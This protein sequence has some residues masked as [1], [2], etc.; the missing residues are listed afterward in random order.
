MAEICLVGECMCN[1]WPDV[2]ICKDLHLDHM[3]ERQEKLQVSRMAVD[4][5]KQ[6]FDSNANF[7]TSRRQV[8]EAF[9]RMLH[10]ARVEMLRVLADNV[11]AVHR[12]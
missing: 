8:H 11:R 1:N 7:R 9:V 12:A 6:A 4:L 5:A 10:D 3:D 2:A